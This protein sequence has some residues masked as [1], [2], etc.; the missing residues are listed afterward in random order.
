M[1]D[2]HREPANGLAGVQNALRR[3]D[4]R[5]QVADVLHDWSLMV[6]LDGLI[7]DGA[8]LAGPLH[9][10]DV[11]T[12]TLHATVNWDSADAYST[13]GAP[14]NG[15]DYVRLRDASGTYLDGR[16]IRTL[17]FTGATTFPPSPVQWAVDPDPPFQAGNQALY[18]EAGDIRDE[19]IVRAITV[20]TGPAAELTFNALWNEEDLFDYGF[21]Q[22]ST[23]D[24]ATYTSVAC[25]DTTDEVDPFASPV[26]IRTVPGFTGF[27]GGW[28]PQVCDLS[29]Y[30]GQ[31]VLLAFRAFND[32]F[33]TGSEPSI[34][35]GF[36]VDDVSVGG[37]LIADGTTLAAWRSITE[38]RNIPVA[39]FT[40]HIISMRTG[41]GQITV[42]RLPLSDA[43]TLT[44]PA[45]VERFID[46]QADF[47]AAVVFHDDPSETASQYAPYRLSVNGVTQPGGGL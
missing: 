25:T 21:V 8:K 24:G 45:N 39:G 37:T 44:N 32:T 9:E 4:P 38:T 28:R 16:H 13:P 17:G 22:I 15:A 47:V 23:D 30:A 12:P 26:A 3:V 10:R 33:V 43:F 34:A 27:S 20:P 46:R 31:S 42:R 6:A 41:S 40:V 36:W 19:A 11:T 14:D 1:G 2:L 7:D 35:P 5:L 29:S 18:S